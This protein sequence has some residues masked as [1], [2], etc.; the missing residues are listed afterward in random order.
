L[1]AAF[2]I[3]REIESEINPPRLSDFT[4]RHTSQEPRSGV[5]PDVGPR[6][7]VDPR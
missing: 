4:D 7:S 5:W 3:S 1:R 6:A 2:P